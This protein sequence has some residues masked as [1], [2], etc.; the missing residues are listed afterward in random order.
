MFSTKSCPLPGD[1]LL[2]KYVDANTYT[3]CY[4]AA[5]PAS[6]TQAQFI[7]AFYT[8]PIFKLERAMLKWVAAKPS[9]DSDA[10]R[11]AEGE[12]DHF[13]AWQVEDRCQNQLLLSDFRGRTRSWLM[14][15]PAGDSDQAMTLLFFGSAVVPL[16]DPHSG[17][18]RL[19]TI[20]S[21]LLGFHK[22]YSRILL[23]AARARLKK[24][25]T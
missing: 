7:S 20:F 13:A 8:T 16:Q 22:I 24:Q 10:R 17:E 9:L 23:H 18:R 19:G 3:D 21:A 6:V 1:A 14:T 4:Q 2:N 25:L 11:L 5:L 12:I 15:L